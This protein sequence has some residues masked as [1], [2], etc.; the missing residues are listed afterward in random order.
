MCQRRWG[1]SIEQK[2]VDKCN[3][4]ILL[5][6]LMVAVFPWG[7]KRGKEKPQKQAIS[8]RWQ[9][10]QSCA[11]LEDNWMGGLLGEALNAC[12]C[13]CNPPQVL[14]K[15]NT[16]EIELFL[17]NSDLTQST[18]HKKQWTHSSIFTISNMSWLL[19]ETLQIL[20]C[21][22]KQ[23]MVLTDSDGFGLVW[24]AASCVVGRQAQSTNGYKWPN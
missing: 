4:C 6:R 3:T 17:K 11:A 22:K 2:D 14:L 21:S 18:P 5:Q 8:C 15:G 1:C 16:E 13:N 19:L 20:E 23:Y 7:P 24:P 9:L 10:P 12:R